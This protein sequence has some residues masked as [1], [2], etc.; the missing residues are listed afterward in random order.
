MDCPACK[1]ANAPEA[2]RCTACGASLSPAPR[3]RPGRRAVAEESDTPFG[4]LGRGPNRTALVAYRLAVLG[5]VPGLGLVL[6]PVA[7]LMAAYA[8]RRGR[9]DPAFTAQGPATTAVL[10]GLALTLTNWAGLYL[11]IRGWPG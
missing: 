5:L 8:R 2:T 10:L 6:G 11:M 9:S 3:P 1:V 4:P 7:G